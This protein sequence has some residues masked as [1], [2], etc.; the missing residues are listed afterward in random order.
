MCAPARVSLSG[1]V[2]RAAGPS[3]QEGLSKQSE[4]RPSES[5]VWGSTVR[6]TAAIICLVDWPNLL[7][8]RDMSPYNDWRYCALY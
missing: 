4:E 7:N 6:V 3:G 1:C 5:P 2:Y 8:D